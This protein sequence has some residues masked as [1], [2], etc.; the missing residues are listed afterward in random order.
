DFVFKTLRS[1]KHLGR[2]VVLSEGHAPIPAT[3]NDTDADKNQSTNQSKDAG[4]LAVK[5]G[6]RVS[7]EFL[8]NQHCSDELLS[9]LRVC[10]QRRDPLNSVRGALEVVVCYSTTEYRHLARTIP[11]SGEHVLEV[12]CSTGKASAILSRNCGQLTA[13]DISTD[14]IAKCN[15]DMAAGVGAQSHNTTY[16]CFDVFADRA[17]LLDMLNPKS[18]LGHSKQTR[19]PKLA[20]KQRETLPGS[21]GLPTTPEAAMSTGTNELSVKE[22]DTVPSTAVQI[23]TDVPDT[24]AQDTNIHGINSPADIGVIFVDIGGNRDVHSVVELLAFLERYA[25]DTCEVVVVKSEAL[26]GEMYAQLGVGL[27]VTR[28]EGEI[29]SSSGPDKC[30]PGMASAGQDSETRMHASQKQTK[31]NGM[32]EMVPAPTHSSVGLGVGTA[33][34]PNCS[35][36]WSALCT[37]ERLRAMAIKDSVGKSSTVPFAANMYHQRLSPKSLN[38]GVSKSSGAVYICRFHNYSESGCK[39]YQEATQMPGCEEECVYDHD[40]CHACLL[41]GHIARQCLLV[42]KLGVWSAN[43]A[44]NVPY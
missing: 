8:H 4:A 7:V 42:E 44:G 26:C 16:H 38:F 21:C 2:A 1:D 39:Q 15:S 18:G 34:M 40:H 20:C 22:R 36:W 14:C 37:R 41:P 13:I 17:C 35:L 12:G 19:S 32:P 43:D 30:G 24:R 23:S 9:K 33:W 25:K 10:Y 27:R 29:N 11:H 31:P 5:K 6:E 3:C 28:D